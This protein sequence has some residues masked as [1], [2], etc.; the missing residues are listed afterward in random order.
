MKKL[1]IESLELGDDVFVGATKNSEGEL[2]ITYDRHK[3]DSL[4]HC[5][6]IRY[7][8]NMSSVELKVSDE[9]SRFNGNLIHMPMRYIVDKYHK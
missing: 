5:V 7:V 4:V 8:P 9:R 6:F 3:I 2:S 1:D